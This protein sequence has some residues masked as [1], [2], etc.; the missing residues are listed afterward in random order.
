MN[1]LLCN[2]GDAVFAAWWPNEERIGSPSWYPGTIKSFEDHELDGEYG[3][4]RYYNILFDDGDELDAVQD[5]F[6]FPKKEYLLC[7][8]KSAGPDGT[9]WPGIKNVKDR[10]SVDEWASTVGW[11]TAFV[12][13]EEQSF[14]LLMDALR[15]RDAYIVKRKGCLTKES[16]LNL[17]EEWKFSHPRG[18]HHPVCLISDE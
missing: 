13:G 15:A 8:R 11:Y 14:P 18:N 1:H 9:S 4:T 16:D 5:L 3:P 2:I 6:V 10:K 7:T 17:P 12:D